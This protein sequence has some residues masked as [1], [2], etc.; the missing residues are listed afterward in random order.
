MCVCACHPCLAAPAGRHSF[1]GCCS[2]RRLRCARRLPARLLDAAAAPGSPYAYSRQCGVLASLP[3]PAAVLTREPAV[4][5]MRGGWLA[6]GATL[7]ALMLWRERG[8]LAGPGLLGTTC[9][10]W[11]GRCDLD[12]GRWPES[13]RNWLAGRRAGAGRSA[14]GGRADA[15]YARLLAS[16]LAVSPCAAQRAAHLSQS[17]PAVACTAG[18][19]RAQRGSKW[20]GMQGWRAIC[21]NVKQLGQ[22][23]S[24]GISVRFAHA[25]FRQSDSSALP[26]AASAVSRHWHVPSAHH[27]PQRP[28]FAPLPVRICRARARLAS[29]CRQSPQ[30]FGPA[31]AFG[32]P[33][34]DR[35]PAVAAPARA[36]QIAS[37]RSRAALSPPADPH[38]RRRRLLRRT[39]ASPG[40]PAPIA[41]R[42]RLRLRPRLQRRRRKGRF[43]GTAS[44]DRDPKAVALGSVQ[45]RQNVEAMGR[46]VTQRGKRVQKKGAIEFD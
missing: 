46:H 43:R 32:A 1:Y 19:A 4:W 41:R 3:C 12:C 28:A 6:V 37:G 17:Q 45:P 36:A 18:W 34:A 39:S 21:A 8:S 7:L 25:P 5:R 11:P 2:C 30:P 40:T 31:A 44:K 26:P 16:A 9:W 29:N 23:I 22:Q 42:P 27:P 13:A 38:C 35:D 20:A 33:E 24:R 10:R 15:L 14:A